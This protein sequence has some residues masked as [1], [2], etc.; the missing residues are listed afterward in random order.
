LV[1]LPINY[2][3]LAVKVSR[4]VL[5]FFSIPTLIKTLFAPW[6]RD[7]YAPR[8]A[9]LD[10]VIKIMFDNFIS[11][12][13]G[14]V[15]RFFTIIIGLFATLVSFIFVFLI[16]VFWLCLPIIASLAIAWGVM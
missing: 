13:I 1:D 4:H 5:I 7:I 3:N 14:F 6:K 8:N 16:L 15:V 12:G 9:S 10:V 11:R 2:W